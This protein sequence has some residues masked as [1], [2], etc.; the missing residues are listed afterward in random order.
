MSFLAPLFLFGA[1]AVALPVIFHLIRRTSREKTLFS[2]LMFLMPT[3]PRVTRRSRLEN[4]FLLI[5]RC[6]VLCLLALGFSRPLI[7]KALPPDPKAG[8]AKKVI[9]LLDVSASMRRGDLWPQARA[10]T[11]DI[12]Q[13][14]S[15]VDQAALFTFDRQVSRMITF[16]QWSNMGQNERT[17]F[18]SKRLAELNPGWSATH[19]GNALVSAA[20]ALEENQGPQT[21]KVGLRQIIL[22]TD[23]QEGSRLESLQG[24]EWPKGIEL[25]IEPLKARRPTNAG[26]QLVMDSADA[27]KA[28]SETGPRI[29]VSN[30]ADSKREQFQVGWARAGQPGFLG[31]PVDVY[32]PPGQS[33]IVAAP[34]SPADAAAD[35]L[36]LTGDDEDFDNTVYLAPPKAEQIHVL[37]AGQDA[38]KDPAQCLYYLKRAFQ[39]TRRQDVQISAW[40]SNVPA[41]PVELDRVPLIIST[42]GLA[43]EQIKALSSFLKS[44]KM[45]LLVLKN[46]SA[47]GRMISQLAGMDGLAVE[48]APTGNY[49]MF[50]QIDFEHPLFAPFAAPRFSDFTKIHFWK[51]RRL[52]VDKTPAVKV[53]ARFDNGDPALLQIS[54]G[55]GTLLVLTA[56]WQP[57]DS[58]LALSSKFVPLLYSILEQSVGIKAQLSQYV[59]GD[60]VLLPGL[61]SGGKTKQ[62][63]TVRRPDGTQ[64]TQAQGEKFS[65]TDLP[66][67]YTVSL[68]DSQRQR[69]ADAESATARSVS[70]GLR[71]S[72]SSFPF[73]VNLDAAESRTAPLPVEELERLGVPVKAAPA[74]TAKQLERKRLRLQAAEL[75]QRQK[76]WRWLI[77]A[78]LMV[79]IM[80]TLLAGWLTRRTLTNEPAG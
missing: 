55:Q 4:I 51:H 1:L 54:V 16:E 76:L 73:A 71:A 21:A 64:M 57:T 47:G 49:A 18:A 7:Q 24:Y 8:L 36:V 9:V 23:L 65:Q 74:Q 80:E 30:S 48:E 32:V 27:E 39:Q 15:P 5:L 43:A 29:R 61:E 56:G 11:A 12:L 3:P 31:A 78:A 26:L 66:G 19:L 69:R 2:S 40:A 34:K 33:R 28:A 70:A 50:G 13:H 44:G 38:E 60:T 41:P 42:D 67:I 62:T 53:L 25:Q 79:L 68:E 20:E 6:L 59:V 45:V 22:I 14:A 37:F 72:G 63:V 35:R 46:P 17:A 10:K 75:E 52:S 58:Q 77:V